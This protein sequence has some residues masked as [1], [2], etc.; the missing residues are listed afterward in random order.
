MKNEAITIFGMGVVVLFLLTVF[1]PACSAEG[2]G[3]RI[4]TIEVEYLVPVIGPKDQILWY[5][6]CK[7]TTMFFEDGTAYYIFELDYEDKFE[8]WAAPSGGG[9]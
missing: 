1:I 8:F 4:D 7:Q 6:F 2:H 5:K 9:G 3:K